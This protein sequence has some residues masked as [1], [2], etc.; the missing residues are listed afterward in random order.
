MVVSQPP[1]CCLKIAPASIAD[2]VPLPALAHRKGVAWKILLVAWV[3]VALAGPVRSADTEEAKKLFRSGDYK[4]C[5]EMAKGEVS[6]NVW[7]EFWPK[8]LIECY[9]ATGA[10]E[11]A[12]TE[13]EAAVQRFQS[14][15]RLRMLGHQ[16]YRMN[17]QAE[18]GAQQLGRIL[19]LLQTSPARFAG[20]DDL[21]ALG[22]YFLLQG[23]D[24]K[25]VLE[26]CYDR[27]LKSDPKMVEAHVASARLAL[28]K[29]D[30][31]VAAQSL[32]KAVK[33]DDTDPEIHYL[34]A[35]AWSPSDDEKTTEHL[36]KALERNPKHIP[37]LL[38][39]AE[40]R[41]GAEDYVEAEKLL[42]EVE[43][44]NPRLPKL[45]ALRAAIAHLEARHKDE[46]EFRRKGLEPFGLNPEVDYVIGKHLSEHYRFAD[47]VTYQLRAVEMDRDYVPAKTQLAQDLLRLGRTEQGWKLVDQVRKKDPYD[48]SI[49]NLKQLETQLAK[50]ATLEAPGFVVRMDTKEAQIYGH[51]VLEILSEARTTL[52]KKYDVQLEEP[53][54]VEI[55]PK[56]KDF[57]I[58]TFGMPGGSGFLGVC[59]GRLITANSPAALKVDSNWKSVL[60]HEY[61]HVVTL[62]KTKNKMPRWL[63]EGISVYEER[64][65]DSRWG[66]SMD[67]T[68]RK[69][70]LS[71]DLVPVSKLSGAFLQPKTPMHLQ[72][73]YYESSMVV[74]FWIEKYGLA[75]LLRV[76]N[77]LSV[78]MPIYD[79]LA[80][81]AASMNAI[82]QEFAV[83]IQNL[84]RKLGDG[85]S[86]EIFEEVDMPEGSD[87][88][89]W[90]EWFNDHPK[91]YWGLRKVSETLL[92]AK[93]WEAH[94]HGWTNFARFTRKT[95]MLVVSTGCWLPFTAR[96]KTLSTNGRPWS[97]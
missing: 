4:A 89:E 17:N 49:F 48:V 24:P 41:M 55:F 11:S 85:E 40:N 90:K 50:F 21:V 72:F 5:I 31:Q 65:R 87:P 29:Y 46:G 70:V 7:N 91:N 75:S 64:Q 68:Y 39:R 96:R 28:D 30:Y 94:F 1:R 77:D 12:L 45:W 93:E 25:Q 97:S 2:A 27:A 9:L 53:I 47:G 58:R 52:T 83:Y 42:K 86:D 10:Y 8:I 78:G 60:W 84:A 6:R 15:I 62:Q 71:Q 32:A 38:M 81:D 61:C 13:Y 88:A 92:Q 54:Y 95:R 16:A 59:F 43:S 22:E 26:I 33:L 56:Q 69:M 14:S 35:R 44:V 37:T 36:I 23:E 20:R 67:P 34:L 51:E 80:R 82:D 74:E 73:A 3:L 79:A 57:A 66:Q 63:S 76:L 19:E 18:K